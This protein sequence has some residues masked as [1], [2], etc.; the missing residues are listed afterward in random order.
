MFGKT[1]QPKILGFLTEA[2][3]KGELLRPELE[4]LSMLTGIEAAPELQPSLCQSFTGPVVDRY[5]FEGQLPL[6]V[7]L[8]RVNYLPLTVTLLRVSYR[9]PLRF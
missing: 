3:W 6:T 5:A 4:L 8:L 7:T 9:W 2:L 1:Y